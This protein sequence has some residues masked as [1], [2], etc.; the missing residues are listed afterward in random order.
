MY[1]SINWPSKETL[2]DPQQCGSADELLA[3]RHPLL[4]SGKSHSEFL[5]C[6]QGLVDCDNYSP[7]LL[8][9]FKF[10]SVPRGSTS[11]RTL[12]LN[13]HLNL[14]HIDYFPFSIENDQSVAAANL[15]LWV[16]VVVLLNNPD[17]P[18]RLA[19]NGLSGYLLF[20]VSRFV[21]TQPP[22]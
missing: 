1:I 17:G 4:V 2:L 10:C 11:S 3:M 6:T 18:H 5:G 16:V 13:I 12:W 20:L 14:A 8:L 15:S 22:S 19:C 21:P 7:Q 9:G